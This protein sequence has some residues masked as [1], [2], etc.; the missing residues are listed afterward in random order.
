MQTVY[1]I[2]KSNLLEILEQFGSRKAFSERLGIE[3]NLLNQYLGKNSQKNIGDK[4]AAKVTDSLCVPPAWLDHPQ[5]KLAIKNIIQTILT[6]DNV[7]QLSKSTNNVE[8]HP[9][10]DQSNALRMVSLTN[11]LKISKGENLELSANTEE[12]KNI[13]VPAG[14]INPIAYLIKGT[15]FTKPYRNGYVVVCEYDGQP[16]AGEEVL[17]FCKNE[18]IYAGEYLFERDGV[19][20]IES[21]DGTNESL[22]KDTIERMSPV[23]MF[24]SPS[25]IK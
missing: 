25:Q 21:V 14:M 6:T 12:I 20:K 17:I 9:S 24:I 19:V 18:T 16:I 5:D 10:N 23:K 15:G 4:F 8:N 22:L 3:Y 7:A 11:I 13:H 2:R 1:E